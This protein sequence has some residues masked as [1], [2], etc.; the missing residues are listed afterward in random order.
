[1]NQNLQI[2][3]RS[4]QINQSYDWGNVVWH[5]WGEA[6]HRLE[7][8]KSSS[9]LV[10]LHGGSGSWSHWIRNVEF[11]AKSR[12][13]WAM[14]IP[15]FGDSELPPNVRDADELVPYLERILKR[16]FGQQPLDVI[17][18]SFGGMTAGLV[19]AEYPKT[20]RK[21]ILVGVPGLGLF[22]EDLPMR[23]ILASMSEKEKR[24]VH[25]HNLRTMMLASDESITEALLDLQIANVSRDR[26]RR[27]RIAR[28]DILRAAQKKWQCS[29]HGIWG[30][31]DALY[32]NT[33]KDIPRVL[34]ELDSFTLI[35]N[36]GHWVMYENPDAFHSV[37]L[38][39]LEE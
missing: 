30:E 2:Q 15:G 39:L 18:F 33:L 3:L 14:D 38:R 27:R 31:N 32:K 4:T 19:A 21:L 26:L 28:T 11:L 12:N 5:V 29:V 6:E 8:V 25:R 37:V 20:I 35:A 7:S 22:G 1:M 34:T 23:G 36:A 16:T 24:Q 9:P 17:G 10:L 13:V